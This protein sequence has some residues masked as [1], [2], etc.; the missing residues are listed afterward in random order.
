MYIAMQMYVGTCWAVGLYSSPSLNPKILSER[1]AR[2][3]LA[4]SDVIT[5]TFIAYFNVSDPAGKNQENW[6]RFD[7]FVELQTYQVDGQIV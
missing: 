2:P 4:R 7:N 6:H 5:L 1:S 3:Y